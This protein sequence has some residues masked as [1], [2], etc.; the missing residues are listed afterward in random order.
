[1]VLK[2]LGAELAKSTKPKTKA[3]KGEGH[4][5]HGHF[6]KVI[7]GSGA[8]S[9]YLKLMLAQ[10]SKSLRRKTF[11]SFDLMSCPRSPYTVSVS[12]SQSRS[13]RCPELSSCQRDGAG[14]QL[15][16]YCR[17]PTPNLSCFSL[18][19]RIFLQLGARVTKFRRDRCATCSEAA[20]CKNPL[21]PACP[22]T[23]TA[24]P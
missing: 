16:G 23:E 9:T 10:T 19:R 3:G 24:E 5:L 20:R 15:R 7:L 8:T 14:V 2:P 21:H 4:S 18:I 22:I 12:V 11:R 13:C 17:P 6:C 1:V